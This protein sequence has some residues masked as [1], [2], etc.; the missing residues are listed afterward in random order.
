MLIA[1]G[2]ASL[3]RVSRLARAPKGTGDFLTAHFAGLLLNGLTPR[4]A[5][6]GAVGGLHRALQGVE[7][8]QQSG[9]LR[10]IDQM[11]GAAPVAI[12][13]VEVQT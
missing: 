3:C 7:R 11:I 9:L 2:E 4:E 5:L 13:P 12:E 1:D 8:N 10:Q 6:A